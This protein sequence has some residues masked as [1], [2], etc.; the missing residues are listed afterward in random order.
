MGISKINDDTILLRPFTLEDAD[1]HLTNDDKEN[2]KW[3][4]GEESTIDTVRNWIIKNLKSWE[5]NGPV[6]SFAI[7]KKQNNQLIGMVEANADPM[8]AKVEGW[9][10]G[11]VNISYLIYP[12]ARKQGYATRAV[13]LMCNFLKQKGFQKA[14]IRIEPENINSLQVPIRNGFIENG[15]IP[16][17]DGGKMLLFEKKLE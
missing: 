10:V 9:E 16:T 4:S 8:V 11:A 17:K 12:F 2:V 1:V 13:N 15:S 14:V 3:L 7:V 6:Y 5:N